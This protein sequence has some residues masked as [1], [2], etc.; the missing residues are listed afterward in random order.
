MEV[1]QNNLKNNFEHARLKTTY[2]VYPTEY[3]KLFAYCEKSST[4]IQKI[5]P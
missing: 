4:L 5:A 2:S 3:D 1:I